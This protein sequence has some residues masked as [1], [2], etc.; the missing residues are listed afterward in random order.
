MIRYADSDCLRKEGKKNFE[1]EKELQQEVSH[2]MRQLLG[3]VGEN[4]DLEALE[5]AVRSVVF[6][7]AAKLVE[8]KLNSEDSDFQGSTLP[9]RCG[10]QA[11]FQGRRSKEFQSILGPLLLRR[12][13]YYCSDCGDGFFPRDRLLGLEG[14]VLTPALTRMT[15]S[16][17]AVVSFKEASQLLGQLAGVEVD[18]KQVER[19]AESLGE[20]IARDERLHFAL[21]PS[22]QR[23][24]TMYLGMDG[25]GIPMRASELEGRKGKQSDGSAKTREVKLCTV[26]TAESVDAKGMPVRDE[27]SVSYS[28]AIEGA[29]APDWGSAVAPFIQR[30]L[31]ETTRRGFTQAPRR[32]ILGDGAA[33]IWNVADEY[34]PHAIQVVDRFHAKEHLSEI[35]KIIWPDQNKQSKSWL[36]R[37]FTQLDS[38]RI[39]KIISSLQPFAPL[40]RQIQN[41]IDYFC[42]NTHRMR[43][44]KFHKQRICTSSGVVEAGCKLAVATR[45]KRPGMHWSLRGSN[46]IL[47]L[48]CCRL[49]GR[50]EDF[51]ERRTASMAP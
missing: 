33:W 7:I 32:V 28:A 22:T 50:Y 14:T 18:A 12:A 9:C 40:N 17:A 39:E 27:G 49:S 46:A 4:L 30:V 21:D 41:C 2:E 51:W 29:A 37:R 3:H 11:R 38:G 6:K 13:Y 8:N 43:Y 48:R 31:R 19:T 42:R 5:V 20:E 34:F 16:A 35:C 24:A 10:K 23:A 44:A 15:G 45:L 47:A 25:T 26:W 1:L 36:K